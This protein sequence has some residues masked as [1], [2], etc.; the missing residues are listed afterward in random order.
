MIPKKN[1]QY[2][3]H[4]KLDDLKVTANGLS[5]LEFEVAFPNK[6]SALYKRVITE[7]DIQYHI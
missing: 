7:I 6:Y 1:G 3:D 5:V 2:F 4:F